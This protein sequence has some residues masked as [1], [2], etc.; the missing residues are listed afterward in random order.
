LHLL[1]V[2]IRALVIILFLL[3]HASHPRVHYG[4]LE[5]LEHRV[6][7]EFIIFYGCHHGLII[8]RVE[9]VVLANVFL[10]RATNAIQ[11]VT[12]E[13]LQHGHN[14]TTVAFESKTDAM[15]KVMLVQ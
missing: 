10:K 7:I 3:I 13:H 4:T 11:I 5:Y 1:L 14:S 2:P 8:W 6:H 12:H 15:Y 9:M